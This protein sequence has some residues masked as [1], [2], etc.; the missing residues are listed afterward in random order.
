[1]L[2]ECWAE[3]LSLRLHGAFL[4]L[5]LIVLILHKCGTLPR[6]YHRRVH[7]SQGEKIKIRRIVGEHIQELTKG[8]KDVILSRLH[9]GEATGHPDLSLLSSGMVEY[10]T[11]TR[12][13][14][15]QLFKLARR[16][17][18]SWLV[19]GDLQRSQLTYLQR[20]LKREM[21]KHPYHLRASRRAAL[22]CEFIQ[23]IDYEKS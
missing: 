17:L 18:P 16:L 6:F 11:E 8:V 15:T 12:D 14:E 1:M 7:L 21:M 4:L 13:A 20:C 3:W 19:A 9:D 10:S 23:V 2:L 5:L 22:M